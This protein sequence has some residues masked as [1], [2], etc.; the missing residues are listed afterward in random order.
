MRGSIRTFV[1]LLILMMVG[2]SV[3]FATDSQLVVLVVIAAFGA[4]LAYSG[5]RAMN[6]HP[7]GCDCHHE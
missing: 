3:D 6:N 1:G 4:A 5:V 2:G 7:Q